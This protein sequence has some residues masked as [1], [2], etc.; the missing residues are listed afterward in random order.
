V[1]EVAVTLEEIRLTKKHLK[2]WMKP[3]TVKTPFVLWPAKSQI[4]TDPLGVV[5]IIGPWNY[6]FQLMM[7]PLIGAL[8]A[9][10]C[11]LLKPSELSPNTSDLLF[12]LIPKYFEKTYVSIVGG[13]VPET[14][15]LLK[16][17]FDHIFFTGSPKVGKVV[18]EAAAKHLTPVTLELGGKSPAVVC[19]DADLE[20][21]AR[22]LVWGKFYNAGQ[23]CVAPDY[24]LVQKSI[25]ERLIEEIKK[26]LQ[27]QFGQ[28]PK[29]SSSFARII[30][31]KNFERL[32]ALLPNQKVI[33]G[34]S[35]DGDQ[36]FIEP[37]LLIEVKWSDDVMKEEIFG[38]LLPILEFNEFSEAIDQINHQPKP[39]AAYLFTQSKSQKD[40]FLDSVSFG[41]GCMNDVMVH[42][43]N[44]HLPFGGVGNS[45]MGSYHGI[46]SFLTFSHQKSVLFRSKYLDWSFRYAPYTKNKIKILK[47]ALGL[48]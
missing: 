15:E 6:P 35:S 2:S 7:A 43:S 27:E 23:T 39:L 32:V 18:M 5:L 1:A 47:L 34:G 9:G 45:G 12:E 41:G 42:L 28:N 3:K 24:L 16:L 37:T 8:A 29:E 36:L 20:I 40:Q 10:N 48:K 25:K 17:P 21:T 11:A 46:N 4:H 31:R 44:P 14:T 33:Q 26:A 19:E 38:P 13:G 22:R 30:N